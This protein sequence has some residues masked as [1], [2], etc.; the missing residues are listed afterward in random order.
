MT[1]Q[2]RMLAAGSPSEMGAVRAM[3]MLVALTANSYKF[4]GCSSIYII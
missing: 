1:E 3:C 2:G 4:Q